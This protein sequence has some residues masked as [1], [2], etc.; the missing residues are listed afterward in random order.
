MNT[1]SNV[2]KMQI[3][4]HH[5]IWRFVLAIAAAVLHFIMLEAMATPYYDLS[6][7]L[8]TPLPIW[9]ASGA[10][11]IVIISNAGLLLSQFLVKARVATAIILSI[12]LICGTMLSSFLVSSIAMEM[13]MYMVDGAI[14]IYLII[15]AFFV[16]HITECVVS[17]ARIN[18]A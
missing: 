15:I 16:I 7:E 12:S 11:I 8:S 6:E 3:S 1:G 4:L 18:S 13:V 2:N 17:Y 14:W 10:A 9:I 5:K